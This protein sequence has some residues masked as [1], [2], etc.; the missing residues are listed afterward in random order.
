M[1]THSAGIIFFHEALAISGFE[2]NIFK[3][4]VLAKRTDVIIA[5]DKL[6]MLKVEL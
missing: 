3:F 5:V 6:L 1:L 2:I 4:F